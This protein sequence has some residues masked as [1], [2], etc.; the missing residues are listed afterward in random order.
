MTRLLYT[1][2]FIN[3]LILSSCVENSKKYTSLK[4]QLDS[5]ESYIQVQNAELDETFAIMNEIEEGLKTIR[6]GEN[7]IVL[8]SGDLNN[9]S[10]EDLKN[11]MLIIQD[12]INN[13]QEQLAKLQK[14]NKVNS[15]QFNKRLASLEKELKDKSVI[16]TELQKQLEIKEGQLKLKN[17]QIY[18]LDKIVAS[19]QNNMSQLNTESDA[20][21][22]KVAKQ[23]KE[24]YSA[25]YIIGPKSELIEAGVM[26]KGGLFKSAKISYQAEKNSFIK[27]DYRDITDIN[28][29]SSKAKLLSIHPKGTYS[30][31]KI[32]DE[33]I[34][35]ISNPNEFWEQ[36]K[37]LVIQTQ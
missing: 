23:E 4:T 18:S 19:L 15:S 37:Y 6:E 25:Y 31:E 36:T 32:G 22:D 21:K 28:T 26:T 1:I 34:L 35:T 33:V 8:K 2:L 14:E 11:D 13:Y 30:L 16:I 20:L 5:L 10:R 29:N 3:I 17:Q 7:I 24:L 9:S 12:V 27:I